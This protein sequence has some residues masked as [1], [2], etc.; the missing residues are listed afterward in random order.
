MT[1][2]TTIAISKEAKADAQDAKHERET[3]NEY[4]Q[5]C[6]EQPPELVEFVELDSIKTTQEIDYAYLADKVSEQIIRELR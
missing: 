5:R 1:D 3:W 4:L 2:K 6:T